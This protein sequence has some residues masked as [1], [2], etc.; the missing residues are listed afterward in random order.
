M[1]IA[2]LI[3][4]GSYRATSGER[5]TAATLEN[6]NWI[7]STLCKEVFFITLQIA[8]EC[9]SSKKKP[10]LSIVSVPLDLFFSNITKT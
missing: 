8:H 1:K 9:M 2:M 10:L 7:I 4:L 6:K 3:F 5:S